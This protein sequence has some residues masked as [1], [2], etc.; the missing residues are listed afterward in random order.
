MCLKVTVI[1]LTLSEVPPLL[2]ILNGAK[3]CLT[4]KSQVM[5]PQLSSDPASRAPRA[6]V[7]T[8]CCLFFWIVRLVGLNQALIPLIYIRAERYVGQTGPVCC[9][10]WNQST[11]TKAGGRL[12]GVIA[13]D[14]DDAAASTDKLVCVRVECVVGSIGLGKTHQFG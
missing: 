7:L 13:G 2:V 8:E 11:A 5:C 1:T 9:T 4:R 10:L 6:Q 3:Q 14:S 12:V